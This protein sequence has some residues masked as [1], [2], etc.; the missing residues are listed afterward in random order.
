VIRPALSTDQNS[1]PSSRP[2][3]C[4]G[5][6]RSA[7]VGWEGA[8]SLAAAALAGH[9]ESTGGGVV[10][11]DV[12]GDYFDSPWA[13]GEQGSEHGSV[14]AAAGG[15]V[16]QADS[17]QAADLAVPA[18]RQVPA[19]NIGQINGPD[20]VLAVH[21]AEA[22]GLPEHAPEASKQ[23]S[24]IQKVIARCG[25]IRVLPGTSGH[26]STTWSKPR[27]AKLGCR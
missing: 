4:K 25:R 8:A 18:G 20:Q 27:A 1:G 7:A 2:R 10:A 6:H 3:S 26:S 14:S 22:P 21:A 23:S 15:V 19:R 13:T 24:A 12:E 5:G 11:V 17:H 16:D 9:G